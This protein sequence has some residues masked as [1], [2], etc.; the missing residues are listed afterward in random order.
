MT[1]VI[2]IERPSNIPFTPPAMNVTMAGKRWFVEPMTVVYHN[3]RREI[4]DPRTGAMTY[5]DPPNQN[6]RG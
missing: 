6:R 2:K 3:G 5:I 1:Q 4:W